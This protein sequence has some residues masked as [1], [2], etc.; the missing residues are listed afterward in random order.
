MIGDRMDTDVVAGLEAGLSTVLVLT[1]V[2]PPR[3][4]RALLLPR[5]ADR[6][7][8]RRAGRR[9][10]VTRTP[11]RRTAPLVR[12]AAGARHW[13]HDRR[14]HL[15]P[16]PARRCSPRGRPRRRRS[17]CSP[18]ARSRR[19][20]SQGCADEPRRLARRLDLRARRGARVPRDRRV[21][22]AR[23][24][25]RDRDRARRRR[26]RPGR[27]E[28]AADR[29]S[30]RGWPPRSATSPATLLGRRL[31]RRFLVAHGP[32]VGVTAPRLARVDALLR[33]PRRQGDPDRPL[34]RP[35]ARGRAV[36]GR[37]L[38]PARCA[39]SCRSASP[40]RSCGRPPSR[41]RATPSTSPS[42]PPP[43]RSRT[44]RSR[45]R[46]SRRPRSPC[47]TLRGRRSR[48]L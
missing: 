42:R 5:L 38:G 20:T 48:P 14:P 31:G 39:A 36:R 47:K 18:R 24:A 23:R 37:R 41:S 32:R 35:R 17:S 46:C 8:G 22:R 9:A 4:G 25:G 33:P 13:R 6:R 15:A 2:T 19:P 12:D 28:P 43:A 1:G 45:W 7:L 40:A 11:V 34:R 44:A 26:R 16:R 3:G 10:G 30:P 21:R 29:C 27:G